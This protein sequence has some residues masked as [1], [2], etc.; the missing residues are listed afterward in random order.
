LNR[1]SAD[2]YHWIVPHGS[3]AQKSTYCERC[4]SDL[5]IA[6]DEFQTLTACNCDS[7]SIKNKADNGIINI[8]FWESTLHN[9]YE[10]LSINDPGLE[11]C[12]DTPFIPAYCVKIPSGNQFSILLHSNIK[13]TQTFRYEVEFTNSGSYA[14]YA[15]REES[16]VYVHDSVF[17]GSDTTKFNFCYVDSQNSGWNLLDGPDRISRYKIVKPGDSL[18]VKIHIY[19]LTEHNFLA[20]SWRD[21]G[22]YML[23]GDKTIKPKPSSKLNCEQRYYDNKPF[24]SLPSRDFSRFTKKP[25]QMRFIFLTDTSVPDTSDTKLDMILANIIKHTDTKLKELK[26]RYAQC[27]KRESKI[28]QQAHELEDNIAIADM[29]LEAFRDFTAKALERRHGTENT[30]PQNDSDR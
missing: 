9:F 2:G 27:K 6:G 10:T 16:N 7:F 19:D 25:M 8:S 21:L 11:P 17:V 5:H 20:D 29:Q 28:M 15:L 1:V 26:S 4:A 12:S 14:A 22:Q 3:T 30:E 24:L 13:S 23:T 18:L